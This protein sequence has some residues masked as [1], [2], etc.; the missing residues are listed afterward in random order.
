M[1]YIFDVQLSLHNA[2]VV[3]NGLKTQRRLALNESKIKPSLLIGGL[4]VGTVISAGIGALSQNL[5]H[6]HTTID[7]NLSTFVFYGLFI[8]M[9]MSLC[10]RLSYN[11]SL[12]KDKDR[13]HFRI[14]SYFGLGLGTGIIDCF[15]AGMSYGLFYIMSYSLSLGIC[16][17]IIHAIVARGKK[18]ETHPKV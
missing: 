8:G 15:Y 7:K 10:Y 6:T 12:G 5:F 14:S 13:D 11:N 17:S 1:C 3:M 4:V 18:D 9:L 2:R 16:L